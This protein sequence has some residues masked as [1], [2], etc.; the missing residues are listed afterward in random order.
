MVTTLREQLVGGEA[1]VAG[2]Y[3]SALYSLSE[4]VF[5]VGDHGQVVFIN[6]RLQELIGIAAAD[7]LRQ[8]Y[9]TIF[10]HIATHSHDMRRTLNDLRA[11]LNS[12]DAVPQVTVTLQDQ[13]P[14]MLQITLFP[15]K[16]TPGA[17]PGQVAWGG[18]V[19]DSSS[20]SARIAQ[21]SRA[22]LVFAQELRAYLMFIKG[23][24]NT[25]LGAQ[26][27]HGDPEHQ[28]YLRSIDSSAQQSVQLIEQVLEISR[29][30]LGHIELELR[31]TD[32][33][34]LILFTIRK[35][36]LPPPSSRLPPPATAGLRM[37][38]PDDLPHVMADP[39]RIGHVLRT[40]LAEPM[41]HVAR[42]AVLHISAR[43]E[44]NEVEVNIR[45]GGTYGLD[46]ILA[47]GIDHLPLDGGPG[48]PMLNKIECRLYV[49][50]GLIEAHHGRFWVART[51]DQSVSVH[52]ALPIAPHSAD[53]L[54]ANNVV[55][56][57]AYPHPEA[58]L[59]PRQTHHRTR[60]L[61]V[62]DDPLMMRVLKSHLQKSHFEVISAGEGEKALEL[63]AV[64]TPNLILLDVYLPDANGF[65]LC[66]RLREFS[67]VPV[68]MVTNSTNDQDVI[69]GLS[70]GADDYLV[71]PFR[72][73]ELLARIEA[74]LRRSHLADMPQQHQGKTEFR[75]GDLVMD[76]A[77]HKV[78]VRGNPVKL[79]P[80][81]YKL[82]YHLVANAGCILT[83]DQLVAKVWGPIFR[84]ETQYL[85]VN[86][87]RLRA[88]LERDPN[89]PEYI[90]TERGVGY[91][92]SAPNR[93]IP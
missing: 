68:I 45:S 60:V 49:A 90:L 31:P 62:E 33:K 71:K 7:A 37:D 93:P 26:D 51:T 85:W 66:A 50:S 86:I 23:F 47:Q 32:I 12:L 70:V 59:E 15:L 46:G 64:E 65:D 55:D 11:A 67:S 2:L 13:P 48:M 75:A 14:R 89:K 38:I 40:L 10:E 42:G 82:L 80:I 53:E 24:V 91:Y 78:T 92:F 44:G 41:A 88:K 20:E 27:S 39:L 84:Q 77:H 4:G 34:R 5:L 18:C 76:F 3:E 54:H 19:R 72:T 9:A 56:L 29:L 22:L 69:R 21:R 8:P 35:L 30:E 17:F 61:I 28:E 57:A 6:P 79:T 16:G 43:Q 52:F 73:V 87:S 58:D 63:A 81:E 36:S 74:V 1:D 25:L 83:H